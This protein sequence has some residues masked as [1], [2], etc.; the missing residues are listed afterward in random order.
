[1]LDAIERCLALSQRARG[2]QGEALALT[3]A[4]LDAALAEARAAMAPSVD[5]DDHA[6]LELDLTGYL[7]AWSPGAAQMFGYSA[8]EALGQHVLLSLIHI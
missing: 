1:M 3:L 8:D 5:A 4:S 7:T 6:V 2:E